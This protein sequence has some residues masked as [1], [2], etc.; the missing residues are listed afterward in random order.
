MI[1][2]KKHS[3][4]QNSVFEK[5]TY[6]AIK[7][8]AILVEK[9]PND[10]LSNIL[11]GMTSAPGHQ[12][13]VGMSERQFL[14]QEIRAA[15][16]RNKWDHPENHFIVMGYGV[17]QILTLLQPLGKAEE[18]EEE[19]VA[20]ML[21]KRY[22][23]VFCIM[24][25]D[26]FSEDDQRESGYHT[27]M[28]QRNNNTINLLESEEENP[29]ADNSNEGSIVTPSEKLAQ[30]EA[31]Q[32]HVEQ[33]QSVIQQYRT[34]VAEAHRIAEQ[35]REIIFEQDQ[36][37]HGQ[38]QEIVR[39]REAI[40]QLEARDDSRRSH[41]IHEE[42]SRMQS[43]PEIPLTPERNYNELTY[44]VRRRSDLPAPPQEDQV[45]K[46][47]EELRAEIT[48]LRTER[49]ELSRI[50]QEK[51]NPS[52]FSFENVEDQKRKPRST[53]SLIRSQGKKTIPT[54]GVTFESRDF[55]TSTR[56]PKGLLK[57]GTLPISRKQKTLP[58]PKFLL[59]EEESEIE[60]ETEETTSEEEPRRNETPQVLS[61]TFGQG[62]RV[63]SNSERELKRPY[64][65]WTL[66]QLGIRQFDP[67]R[68]DLLSHIERV[69]RILE[70]VNV[71][72][73]SQKIRLL[74]ASFPEQLDYYEKVVSNEN[75]SN[76]QKFA[77][78]LLAIMGS[79][80]R[81]TAH[82]F[83][84]CHRNQAED[85]L[86]YFF[87]ITDLYKGSQG[88]MGDAWQ[89]EPVH[90]NHIYTK[91]FQSLYEPERAELERKLDRYIERGKLTVARLKK[92]LIRINKMATTKIKAEAPSKRII[93]T[94]QA[95]TPEEEPVEDR[96]KQVRCYHCNRLGHYRADCFLRQRQLA[97][98][99]ANWKP[100]NYNYNS[101]GRG[102]LFHRGRGR[103]Y[104]TN[105]KQVETRPPW[106]NYT[107]L[108]EKDTES[109][110]VRAKGGEDE[111]VSKE[112]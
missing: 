99:S 50:R 106:R 52:L 68:N 81:V 97:N 98:E 56:S 1:Q 104:N 103:G 40:S 101:R 38:D 75:K 82:Q 100:N 92:E 80:V 96:K 42:G 43:I 95:D 39:L 63:G 93:L 10:L 67:D 70:E 29:E 41:S 18:D 30:I 110:K 23:D 85:V 28:N 12:L 21:I 107:A 60:T 37:L 14:L 83:M 73:E 89:D 111:S 66:K 51:E 105:W 31:I 94:V 20:R 74:M 59:P 76:Y 78:E 16:Q 46:T 88:L 36:R 13:M 102:A 22:E 54:P 55:K 58:K 90:A 79:K 33:E 24:D 6:G 8:R 64:K 49:E 61:T 109:T 62:R 47:L 34:E 3:E 77:Q 9:F 35:H 7:F 5:S 17:G 15:C 72:P 4:C 25:T 26:L 44:D 45:R 112:E 53:L 84:Q 108:P 65:A 48:A 91:L 69:S 27:K 2:I 32:H 71:S 57:E 86:H 11:A 19:D 87:R